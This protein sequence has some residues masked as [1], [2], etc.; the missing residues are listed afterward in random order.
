MQAHRPFLVRPEPFLFDNIFHHEVIQKDN[1]FQVF[2]QLPPKN[3]TAS[4]N[5]NLERIQN[6]LRSSE[7]IFSQLSKTPSTSSKAS[8]PSK[9]SVREDRVHQDNLDRVKGYDTSKKSELDYFPPPERKD[10]NPL[11]YR[12]NFD[13]KENTNTSTEKRDYLFGETND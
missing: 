6:Q 2:N 5:K 12:P 7:K 11:S 9:E 3:K 1:S 10:N 8:A 4:T 13:T